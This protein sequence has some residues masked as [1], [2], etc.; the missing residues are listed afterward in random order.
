MPKMHHTQPYRSELDKRLSHSGDT[1]SMYPS[2]L[3]LS[4]ECDRFIEQKY[5]HLNLTHSTS[6]A[7]V[8]QS[9]IA[10]SL[11]NPS[12]W[13]MIWLSGSESESQKY[14]CDPSKRMNKW[15]DASPLFNT[16]PGLKSEFAQRTLIRKIESKLMVVFRTYC[17]HR[18]SLWIHSCNRFPKLV[19]LR[20]RMG[21]SLVQSR[22]N[23]W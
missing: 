1:N 7:L 12:P 20:D 13:A 21:N 19:V 15:V 22:N 18:N 6:Y 2:F 4:R 11:S 16:N 23:H 3:P 10:Y 8:S 14:V 5:N 9:D 17:C